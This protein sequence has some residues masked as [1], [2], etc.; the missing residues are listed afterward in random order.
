[1]LRGFYYVKDRSA[2]S[3]ICA[4]AAASLIGVIV[5]AELPPA[6]DSSNATKFWGSVNASSNLVTLFGGLFSLT[7]LALWLFTA[8]PILGPVLLAFG[9]GAFFV[10]MIG[11]LRLAGEESDVI[12]I[13]AWRQDYQP[14]A[15]PSTS[16]P[17]EPA[18]PVRRFGIHWD[19]EQNPLCPVDDTL[20][21]MSEKGVL[22]STGEYFEAFLC[23]RC[24]NRY[25]L[26]DDKGNRV[27]IT[28]A[29][30]RVRRNY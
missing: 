20:L 26:R 9:L 1:L 27:R 7:G 4:A 16:N 13:G 30:D 5:M 18:K 19:S 2:I 25:T 17:P 15:I 10:L 22:K 29:K 21:S 11:R 3:F 23:P 6:S 14:K 8:V 12:T 24:K 28:T